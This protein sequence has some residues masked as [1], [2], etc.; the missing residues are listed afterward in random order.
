MFYKM[1]FFV[2]KLNA[3]KIQRNNI[4]PNFFFVHTVQIFI[5]N[6]I[7]SIVFKNTNKSRHM[8]ISDNIF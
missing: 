6:L 2:K 3:L 1:F 8:V 5:E 4:F 7:I